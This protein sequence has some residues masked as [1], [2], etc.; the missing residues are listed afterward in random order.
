MTCSSTRQISCLGGG[1]ACP[2][3]VSREHTAFIRAVMA[4]EV[5]ALLRGDNL[6]TVWICWECITAAGWRQG[7]LNFR[8][9]ADVLMPPLVTVC[10]FCKRVLGRGP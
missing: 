10:L 3:C 6:K 5:P 7:W 8:V 1:L 9:V 4:L 2:R